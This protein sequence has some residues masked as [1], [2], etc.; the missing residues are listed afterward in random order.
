MDTNGKRSDR[1]GVRRRGWHLPQMS[2]P[3]MA[4]GVTALVIALGGW[5][6]AQVAP[7]AAT[8]NACVAKTNLT[9]SKLPHA[10]GSVRFVRR[11]R[12]DERAVVFNQRGPT[13]PAGPIGLRGLTGANGATG[14]KGDPGNPGA[15]GAK[16]DPG[17]TG[18]TGPKGD[19]GNAGSPGSI[20]PTGPAGPNGGTGPTG[21]E[22]P[23]GP[24]GDPGQTGPTGP[25]GPPGPGLQSYAGLLIPGVG[26]ELSE[27]WASVDPA[28][29]LLRR[30]G[31]GQY[32]IAFAPG[33]GCV[34]PTANAE[35]QIAMALVFVDS[36]TAFRVFVV[37]QD[38]PGLVD[39]HF[40]LHV[41][42]VPAPAD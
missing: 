17:N 25:P 21:P 23:E 29:T 13:G 9:R 19:A 12:S 2:T 27:Q 37:P 22:G 1:P 33:D 11:C 15:T 8:I 38:G 3:A 7:E 42:F 10:R 31:Q 40:T 34:V 6:Y 28:P 4:I 20:G 32:S 18:P 35:S 36:C 24:E 41:D 16:G 26:M 30:D 14:A 5:A 39:A